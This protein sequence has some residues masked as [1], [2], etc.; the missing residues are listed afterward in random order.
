MDGAL[1]WKALASRRQRTKAF[2]RKKR[3]ARARRRRKLSQRQ[4]QERLLFA[5]MMAM[6]AF[7]FCSP[8]RSLDKRK[9]LLLVGSYCQSNVLTS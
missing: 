4:A 1:V 8:T 5:M 2:L 9:E 3:L 7:N 6:L